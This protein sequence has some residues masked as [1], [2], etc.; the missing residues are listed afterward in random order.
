MKM[1]SASFGL[2][3]CI[4]TRKDLLQGSNGSETKPHFGDLGPLLLSRI[5]VQLLC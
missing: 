5:Q 2:G 3:D 1:G 4:L